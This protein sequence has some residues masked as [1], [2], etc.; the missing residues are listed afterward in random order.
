MRIIT[1]SQTQLSDTIHYMA[2]LF[3]LISATHLFLLLFVHCVQEYVLN[4][5]CPPKVLRMGDF[6][7]QISIIPYHVALVKKIY[8]SIVSTKVWRLSYK[9]TPRHLTL[10]IITYSDVKIV[11]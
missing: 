9:C 6:Y 4:S 7:S 1:V 10:G 2:P 11:N 3:K 5:C 8:S